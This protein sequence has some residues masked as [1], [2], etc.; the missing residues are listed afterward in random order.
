MKP[1][2]RPVTIATTRGTLD[3]GPATLGAIM[4]VLTGALIVLVTPSL[5]TGIIAGE[6]ESGGWV[7]LQ[8]TPLSTWS[9]VVGK[10]L[11]VA[12]IVLLILLATLPGYAVLWKIDVTGDL[13]AR[14]PQVMI[15]LAL[16]AVMSVLVSAAISSLCTRTAAATA[17]AYSVLVGGAS[18][19]FLFWLGRDAPFPRNVVEKVLTINPLAAAL[20]LIDA[21]G[22]VG[23][24]LL[25]ANWWFMGGVCM[26]SVMVLLVQTWRLT[27]PR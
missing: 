3:W 9:I 2:P 7:L 11:S 6:R 26:A 23:Y 4:V 21:P 27:R 22:F 19:T 8:M 20:T 14:M 1:N 17:L 5:A 18:G 16:T 13:R 25:P 24:H 10:L 12:W 15:T